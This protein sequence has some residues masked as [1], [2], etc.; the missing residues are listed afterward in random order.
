M[1]VNVGSFLNNVFRAPGWAG[2]VIPAVPPGPRAPAHVW[3]GLPSAPLCFWCRGQG[4]AFKLDLTGSDAAQQLP[5][6]NEV[7]CDRALRTA[8]NR[9]SVGWVY[10]ESASV[11]W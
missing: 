2:L 3:A 4:C 9:S 7:N 5:G 10:I 6:L 1:S 8:E 11:A